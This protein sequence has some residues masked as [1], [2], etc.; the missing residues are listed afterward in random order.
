[1]VEEDAAAAILLGHRGNDAVGLICREAPADL[2]GE[3]FGGRPVGALLVGRQ[4]GDDVQT[5]AARRLAVRGQPETL[6]PLAQLDRGFDHPAKGHVG[7]WVQVEHQSARKLGNSRLAIPRMQF[8]SAELAPRP[9]IDT[10]RV[11]VQ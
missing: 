11:V 7:R 5:L 3:G 4:G 8:D 2:L 9:D 1:M 10:C 6:Q